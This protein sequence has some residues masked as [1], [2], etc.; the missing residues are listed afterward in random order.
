MFCDN[1]TYTCNP[2]DPCFDW[3]MPSFGIKTKDK[4]VPGIFTLLKVHVIINSQMLVLPV[5]P[6]PYKVGPGSS[7][8]SGE[9]TP[10]IGVKSPQL[11]IYKTI[12]RGC[13]SIYNKYTH[14]VQMI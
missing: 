11:P 10:L 6:I 14:L 5:G 8:K 1:N 2:N 3:K 13:N 7:Y 12:H 4:W 9:L